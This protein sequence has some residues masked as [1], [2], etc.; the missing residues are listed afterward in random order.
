MDDR[1]RARSEAELG[2]LRAAAARSTL[3]STL[4]GLLYPDLLRAPAA[5]FVALGRK[6]DLP[7]ARRATSIDRAWALEQS[8]RRELDALRGPGAPSASLYA[9][10]EALREGRLPLPMLNAMTVEQG[11]PIVFTPINLAKDERG[12]FTSIHGFLDRHPGYDVDWVT[13]ARLSSTYPWITPVARPEPSTGPKV[14]GEHLSDGGY[15]DNFGIVTLAEWLDA[16]MPTFL[17]EGG[18]EVLVLSIYS[19]DCDEAAREKGACGAGDEAPSDARAFGLKLPE[20]DSAGAALEGASEEGSSGWRSWMAGPISAMLNA[21]GSTQNVRN[22]QT[23]SLLVDRWGAS[24]EIQ[25]VTFALERDLPLSWQMT[26]EEQK[27]L[28]EA[29]AAQETGVARVRA[30]L[31]GEELLP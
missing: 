1:S 24:V 26:P 31:D 5:P 16:V 13:A 22:A 21:R 4:W 12:R 19:R 17:E 9:W 30:F 28:H 10:R 20:I 25:H 11:A 8:W 29:W 15:F 2:A 27:V 18:S 3:R 6:L 7:L 23:L 14:A